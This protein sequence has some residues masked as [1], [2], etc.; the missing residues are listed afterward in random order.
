[1]NVIFLGPP[2]SGKGTQA[3][4]LAAKYSLKHL[5]T[6]DLFREAITAQNALGN[7]IKSYVENGRLVPDELVSEVVF[8]K[9]KQPDIRSSFLLDGY[10]RTM[11]QAKSMD[12]F[13]KKEG[14]AV[15]AI[16]FFS[17]PAADLVKRLSAR[18]QCPKCKEVYNLVTR[19]PKKADT[20]DVCQSALYH[21]PD[22]KEDVVAERLSVYDRQTAPIVDFYKGRPQFHDINAAQ[23]VGKVYN[24]LLQA[25]KRA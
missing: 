2:G 4:Q 24:D 3:K 18:R 12:E 14:I 10:P 20:C 19:V 9:I 5:S 15:D 22:D 7:E 16:I 23:E 25:V 6:G 17:V 8:E 21:R 13:V 11:E 1:M